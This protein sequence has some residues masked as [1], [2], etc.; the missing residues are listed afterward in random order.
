MMRLRPVHLYLSNNETAIV[1]IEDDSNPQKAII[2]FLVG[3]FAASFNFLFGAL[4][5]E[6]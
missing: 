2:F 4:L 1:E 6:S 3:A 5:Y